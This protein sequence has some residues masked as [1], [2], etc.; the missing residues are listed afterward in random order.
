MAY[1]AFLDAN[2]IVTEVIS[3]KDETDPPGNW[4]QYYGDFRGQVCKRTSYNTHGGVHYGPD[5]KPDGEP[6]FRKNYASIGGA[7]DSVLDAFIAPKPFSSWLL[8]TN[9]CLW[10]APVP[11]PS[12]G[13]NY[14]WDEATLSW[15]QMPG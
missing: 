7:Y 4:E 13:K 14:Y 10:N 3:G 15:V 1:Y 6:A 12:D 5:G 8:D 2:N 11:Y 9:T